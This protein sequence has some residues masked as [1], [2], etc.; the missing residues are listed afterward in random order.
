MDFC[1]S[2][3][4]N[5]FQGPKLPQKCAYGSMVTL[6]ND[7]EAVLVGCE[8]ENLDFTEKIYKLTWQGEHLNWVTMAQELKYPRYDAVA[9]LVQNEITNCN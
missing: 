3:T 5:I 6:P 9:M 8:D 4:E 1:F 2:K 7:N